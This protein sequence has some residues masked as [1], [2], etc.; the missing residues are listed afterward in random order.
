MPRYM[1]LLHGDDSV[2]YSPQQMQRIVEEYM[3]WAR[4]LRNEGHMLG[5]DELDGGG[6]VIRGAGAEVSVTDGPFTET[7]ETIGGYFL[8]EAA[9]EAQA[10][11][12]SKQC[13]GLKR[14]GAVELRAVIDH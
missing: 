4:Q 8:I 6:K 11:E 9:N 14:G 10:V 2:E 1:L 13:P 5:G 12:I 3:A 7:K